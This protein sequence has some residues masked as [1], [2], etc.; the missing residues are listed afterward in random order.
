MSNIE[1]EVP[2]RSVAIAN[3]LLHALTEYDLRVAGLTEDEIEGFGDFFLEVRHQAEN[4]EE[5]HQYMEGQE[6]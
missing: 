6:L 2:A 1:L 3:K 5:C 4:C